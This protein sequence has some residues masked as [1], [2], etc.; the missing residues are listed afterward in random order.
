MQFKTF[1]L[2]S[3]DCCYYYTL[4]TLLIIIIFSGKAIPKNIEEPIDLITKNGIQERTLSSGANDEQVTFYLSH[5]QYH[6]NSPKW[7]EH[8]KINGT[9]CSLW[10]CYSSIYFLSMFLERSWW[11][12]WWLFISA[13]CRPKWCLFNWL[14]PWIMHA[15]YNPQI[16]SY[17]RKTNERLLIIINN[18]NKW[19]IN[20]VT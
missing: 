2:F 12:I 7:L 9:L 6:Q 8:L 19:I 11:Q 13:P 15:S 3:Y 14:G 16:D 1:I 5:I 20:N 17:L 18:N 10:E 4:L